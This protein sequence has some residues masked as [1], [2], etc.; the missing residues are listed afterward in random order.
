[1]KG[2]ITKMTSEGIYLD[3]AATTPM[4]AAVV[5]TMSEALAN[6]FGNASSLYAL[7]RQSRAKIERVREQ[8]ARTLNA[9][10][11]DIIFTSGGT[12]ANDSAILQTAKRLKGKGKHIITTAAEHSSVY[13]TMKLLEEWGYRVTYLDFDEEGHIAMDDLARAV[14]DETTMVAIMAGNNEVGSLQDI[15]TIGEFCVE[16]E[17]FFQT[18]TVQTY[19]NVPIDVEA[20]HIDALSLSGHKLYGPKGIGFM[21]YRYAKAHFKSYLPGGNQENQ[22]RAGT[23][24]VPLIVGLGKAI[25]WFEK[26]QDAHRQHLIDLRHYF[27]AGAEA[28]GLTFEVNGPKDPELPHILNLYWPNHPSD[29]V[30]IKLDLKNIYLSAGSA[31]TAGSLE[32]SR[33]LVSMYG[34]D[35]PRVTE[36]LRLSFGEPT[37]TEE[38]DAVLDAL[39]DI[40]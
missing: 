31:C 28:R 37:T 3:Y 17:L 2:T 16:H 26:N 35:S 8:I 1:M 32:P 4:S 30:L 20:Y 14:D 21:Y 15:K 40:Q 33:V 36:S 34:A 27:L 7:G 19:M 22:H 24:S 10:P 23:E 6:D 11:E 29:Q 12:E 5:E 39:A 38:L 25:E 9:Q 13:Q 18:D